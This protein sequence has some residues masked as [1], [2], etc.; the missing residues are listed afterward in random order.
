M[1]KLLPTLRQK[2]RYLVFEVIGAGTCSTAVAAVTDSFSRFFGTLETANAAI[3]PVK[4]TSKRCMVSVNRKHVD[5]LKTALA[6]VK[7]INN[8][9]VILRSVGV[10]GAF[11]AAASNYL[12]GE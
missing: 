5:K 11:N 2:K 1:T 4:S 9:K 3:N 12:R 10:S 8:Q 7:S 6:L